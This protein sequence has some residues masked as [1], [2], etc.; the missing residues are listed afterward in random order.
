MKLKK[1]PFCGGYA[2]V[3]T[4]GYTSFFVRCL[5]CLMQTIPG[6]EEEAIKRWNKRI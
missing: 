4:Y 5:E 1:C 3:L 2:K 6:S